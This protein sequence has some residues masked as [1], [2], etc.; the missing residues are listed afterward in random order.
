MFTSTITTW[1]KS[2]GSGFGD[3]QLRGILHAE[4]NRT[5]YNFKNNILR[6]LQQNTFKIIRLSKKFCVV[7]YEVKFCCERTAVSFSLFTLSSVNFLGSSRLCL[8]SQML[9]ESL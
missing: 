1:P 9:I 8:F 6:I 5:V 7:P 2:N 3:F 4:A